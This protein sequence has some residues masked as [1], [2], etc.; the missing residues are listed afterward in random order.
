MP[1]RM[2]PG[3]PRAPST[4][5]KAPPTPA[6]RLVSPWATSACPARLEA[7]LRSRL[8]TPHKPLKAKKTAKKKPGEIGLWLGN[9]G[10][11]YFRL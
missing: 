11:F 5:Q 4:G 6:L 1:S 3:P 2:P 10:R 8:N 9:L 7:E